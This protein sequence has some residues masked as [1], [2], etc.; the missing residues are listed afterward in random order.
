MANRKRI[1]VFL[2]ADL[3]DGLKALKARDGMPEAEAI[4]RGVGE[5]LKSRGIDVAKAARKRVAPR[6]RA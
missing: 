3:L 1:S 5:Y 4:R 2:D 6:E